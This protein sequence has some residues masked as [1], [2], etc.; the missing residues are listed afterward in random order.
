MGSN[1]KR[2][3]TLHFHQNGSSPLDAP[4]QDAST[5]DFRI[6]AQ[7]SDPELVRPDVPQAVSYTHL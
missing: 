2:F 7:T 4:T 3:T 6:F 1:T 5:I